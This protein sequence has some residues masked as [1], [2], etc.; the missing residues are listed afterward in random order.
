MPSMMLY[1]NNNQRLYIMCLVPPLWVLKQKTFDVIPLAKYVFYLP[2]WMDD[3][4]MSR[5]SC[6]MSQ[7]YCLASRARYLN[8]NYSITTENIMIFRILSCSVLLFIFMWLLYQFHWSSVL[9]CEAFILT[10][11]ILKEFF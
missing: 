3:Y 2:C 6:N 11:K 1:H 8:L 4:D 10:K 7:W 9:R 5:D